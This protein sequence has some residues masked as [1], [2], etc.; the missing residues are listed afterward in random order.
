MLAFAL[1]LGVLLSSVGGGLIVLVALGALA[2]APRSFMPST[3]GAGPME[4]TAGR[5]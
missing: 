2:L 5:Y 4:S 1:F 3:P